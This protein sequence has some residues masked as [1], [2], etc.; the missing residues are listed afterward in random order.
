MKQVYLFACLGTLLFSLHVHALSLPPACP[1]KSTDVDH[2]LC[3]L[4]RKVRNLEAQSLKDTAKLCLAQYR[5]DNPRWRRDDCAA[6][7]L[8]VDTNSSE[9]AC[10]PG[11]MTGKALTLVGSMDATG[12]IRYAV[13]S[14]TQSPGGTPV[15]NITCKNRKWIVV[16]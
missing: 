3:Q 15:L 8:Q 12:N 5:A 7:M 9:L 4:E 10:V 6:Q 2:R 13:S 1:G 16:K 14:S 11:G